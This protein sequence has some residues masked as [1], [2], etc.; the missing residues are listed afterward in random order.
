MVFCKGVPK[1]MLPKTLKYSLVLACGVLALTSGPASAEDKKVDKPALSG[2]WGKKDG[3]LQIEFADKGGM[4][5][6]PHGD[7]SVLAIVCSYTVEKESR[8]K[9]EVT[10]FEGKEEAKKKVQEHLPV[11]FKFSF[12][13]KVNG[14]AARLDDLKGDDIEMLKSHLEGDFEQKK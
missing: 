8:V 1:V 13:W 5:I 11:G 10:G 4:K 7:S 6:V 2:T 14:D 3:G 9:V 12:K